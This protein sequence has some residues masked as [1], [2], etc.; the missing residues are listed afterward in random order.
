MTL[1]IEYGGLLHKSPYPVQMWENTYQKELCLWTV[2]RKCECEWRIPRWKEGEG[3]FVVEI[4]LFFDKHQ[5]NWVQPQ[6]CLIWNF[7]KTYS[8]NPYDLM[9]E[10]LLRTSSFFWYIKTLL[11]RFWDIENVKPKFQPRY[12]NVKN[13][14]IN[15]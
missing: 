7:L 8:S 14:N 4:H 11:K 13:G 6:L 9:P 10:S 1:R 15:F 5:V 2:F 3:E 12:W